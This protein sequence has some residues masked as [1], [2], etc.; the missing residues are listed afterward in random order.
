[1]KLFV[2]VSL[3]TF[4][5]TTSAFLQKP[6]FRALSGNMV[7]TSFDTSLDMVRGVPKLCPELPLTPSIAGN[8]IAIIAYG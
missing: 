1:M 4:A 2:P 6:S 5:L 7:D 8:E 3:L